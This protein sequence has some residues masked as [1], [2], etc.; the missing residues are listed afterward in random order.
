MVKIID[1]DVLFDKF[2][3]DFVYGNIGKVKPEEIENRIPELYVEFGNT[4]LK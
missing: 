1:V 3:S 2:I 4:S